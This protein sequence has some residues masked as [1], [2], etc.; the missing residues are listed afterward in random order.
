MPRHAA[1]AALLVGAVAGVL[2]VMVAT[3]SRAGQKLLLLQRP[4]PWWPDQQSLSGLETDAAA[5]EQA[6]EVMIL[7]TIPKY[8]F[9]VVR[10]V[11]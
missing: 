11:V 2:V 10:L 4:Q 7:F 9:S 6:K 8:L 1:A 3:S 5:A